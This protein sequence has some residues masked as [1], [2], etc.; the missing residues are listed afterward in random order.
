[1]GILLK[2]ALAGASGLSRAPFP[3]SYSQSLWISEKT[4]S[5]QPLS[6]LN[7][8]PAVPVCR[9]VLVSTTKELAE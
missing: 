7:L 1:M 2:P 4:V 6:E 3:Q 9:I 5:G 8:F